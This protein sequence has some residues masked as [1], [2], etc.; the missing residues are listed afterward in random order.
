MPYSV[1]MPTSVQPGLQDEKQ[2]VMTTI[3]VS[4][5]NAPRSFP[6]IAS[7]GERVIPASENAKFQ[8]P[9]KLPMDCK[10][11]ARSRLCWMLYAADIDQRSGDYETRLSALE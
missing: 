2:T 1:S 5:F 6:W 3:K 4:R 9:P 7:K 11:I 10:G 8:C